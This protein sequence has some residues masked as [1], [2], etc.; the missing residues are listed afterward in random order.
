M[1]QFFL[2]L[3]L[4]PLFLNADKIYDELEGIKAMAVNIE[5]GESFYVEDVSVWDPVGKIQKSI[6]KAKLLAITKC[7]KELNQKSLK[8]K[9]H[10][11]YHA[12]G[13][14]KV[15]NSK[16]KVFRHSQCDTNGKTCKIYDEIIHKSLDDYLAFVDMV[17]E[18]EIRYEENRKN[19]EK[20]VALNKEQE[21]LRQQEIIL[22][23]L[24]S[25]CE[26]FGWKDDDD[27]ASCVQQEAYRDLQQEKQKR[28]IK[29]LEQMLA[30]A[31]N[32]YID[33][34]PPLFFMILDAYNQSKQLDN[35]NQMKKDI[36]A[37]KATSGYR[38]SSTEAA[39]ISLYRGNN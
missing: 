10:D 8:R 18:A 13:S 19:Y 2:S 9:H 31:Q 28:E 24:V 35:M 23:A 12:L 36:A 3:I 38:R 7:D 25:R 1:R 16:C 15:K 17:K 30:S 21:R 20:L 34:D 11:N 6:S 37:L 29:R 4:S 14:Q 32:T 33:D 5:T 26:D 39:L 22:T 27:V